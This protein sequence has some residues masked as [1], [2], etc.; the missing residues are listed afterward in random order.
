MND[1]F[2][3]Q[4]V[5]AGYQLRKEFRCVFLLEIAVRQDMVEQ[6]AACARKTKTQADDTRERTQR[7]GTYRWRNPK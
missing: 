4:V 3:M 2:L 6:F 5:H 1:L 7:A